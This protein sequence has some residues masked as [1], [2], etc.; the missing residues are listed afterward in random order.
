[1]TNGSFSFPKAQTT[2]PPLRKVKAE[3][4]RGASNV[5]WQQFEV[6]VPRLPWQGQRE[7]TARAR[8][9]GEGGRTRVAQAVERWMTLNSVSRATQRKAR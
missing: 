2:N 4:A 1:M 8:S 9:C 6:K 5:W 7:G 3:P